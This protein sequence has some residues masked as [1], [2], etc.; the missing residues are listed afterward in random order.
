MQQEIS[1][2]DLSIL[3][4]EP[5]ATQR[6]I[7]IK[8]LAVESIDN[9]TEVGTAADAETLLETHVP[10]L[11]VSALHFEDGTGLDLVRSMRNSERLKDVPF[12]LISSET[13][14]EQL[15]EFKQSGVVAILPKPFTPDHLGKAINATI[16]L[17]SPSEMDLEY[18]DIQDIR[19]LV[20]DDS[21]FARSHIIRVLRNLGVAKITEASDGKDAIH[22]LSNEMFDLVVTDYNMP[23]VDG[24]ELTEFI[25]QK[26]Q[27]SHIPVLMVSSEA[28]ESHLENI[29]QS[30]VNAM[31]DKPF[32]PDMVRRIIF[33]L[34]EQE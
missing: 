18:F 15:E 28:N 31:C 22:I 5:S 25:R 11:V 7:I 17:L 1:P 24:R 10:D 3:L 9:I 12:M 8:H 21:A 32:E 29:A 33:N 34:L 27:Q 19:V 13:R 6:K 30:G 16:D 2:Q 20:V 23:D 26:S 4:V 14:K